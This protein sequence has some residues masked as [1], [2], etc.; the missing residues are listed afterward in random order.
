M[1]P[2]PSIDTRLAQA[3]DEVCGLTAVYRERKAELQEL[4][5][6][7]FDARARLQQLVIQASALSAQPGVH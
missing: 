2:R 7:L 3:R 4:E 5:R 1:N 6:R